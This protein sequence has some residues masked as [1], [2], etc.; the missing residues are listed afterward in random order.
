MAVTNLFTIR[1][2]LLIR[3]QSAVKQHR[4]VANADPHWQLQRAANDFIYAHFICRCGNGM[5][6]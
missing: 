6:I 5:R 3:M 4:G 2:R 1:V